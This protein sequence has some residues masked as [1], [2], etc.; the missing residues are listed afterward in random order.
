MARVDGI[1][2]R[3]GGAPGGL[4]GAA[5]PILRVL[6]PDAAAVINEPEAQ[7]HWAAIA[8]ARPDGLNVWR[9]SPQARP[10]DRGWDGHAF[11]RDVF[12]NLD[13]HH[14]RTGRYPDNI[15]LLNELNLDYERG[16]DHH[17]GGAFDTNPKNWPGLYAKIARFMRDLL[18]SCKERAAD[19]RFAPRWWFQ[20][21]SPGHGEQ[22]DEIAALW[23]PVAKQ[24]DGVCFHAYYDA[25]T[26]THDALWYAETFPA[27]PLLLGEWNTD[28]FPGDRIA[29]DARVR[30][31][32]RRLGEA[33]PRLWACYFIWRWEQDQGR[34]NY[35][36]EGNDARLALWDGRAQLPADDWAA[37]PPPPPLPDPPPPPA[38]AGP[39]PF[40]FWS[41][42]QIAEASGCPVEAVA[43]NWP[44]IVAQ[45]DLAG[46][47][48][49]AVQMAVIGTL[50]IETASTFAP[51]REGC[52][53][54][55]EPDGQPDG[56]SPAE[57]FRRTLRY[58]PWYGRGF[59]QATEAAY[60]DGPKIAAFWGAD[61]N[62]PTFDLRAHPDNLL[63]VDMSAA[64]TALFF[65]DKRALPSASYPEG[66][67]L[68]EAC[69]AFDYEW[70]RRLVQGGTN[71]L[72]RLVAV[73]TALGVPTS[74]PEPAPLAYNADAPPERQ[75]QSW[76]CSIRTTAWMLDTLGLGVEI[77]ALQD[78][79]SPAYVTPQLGLLDG[80]GHGL[81]AVL[82]A[83]LP[84]GTP[85]EVLWA[86]T[87]DDLAARAGRGPCGIGSGGLYHWLGVAR[88]LD[89]Q[90]MRTANPAPNYPPASPLGDRLTRAQ[91]DQWSPWALV[92]VPVVAAESAPTAPPAPPPEPDLAAQIER[93]RV[94]I[95]HLAREVADALDAT[96]TDP[97]GAITS[98][99]TKAEILKR[100][101]A[102]SE[103]ARNVG[104]ELRRHIPEAS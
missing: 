44:R 61:P 48:D 15:L 26:V 3:T 18:V 41:A 90:T 12:K 68:L 60:D 31:R 20:A 94:V 72:D 47:N 89:E 16:E 83:H 40:Q 69:R 75:V 102:A 59:D 2:W 25:D 79:M 78:E 10:A 62:D 57:R 71:G 55:E 7:W 64:H 67:T 58:Y 1:H 76:T 98:K 36:I 65:R 84:P 45:L 13:A 56:L 50:A 88:Q 80:H 4:D 49:R 46:I 33:I 96:V 81:A 91:F 93:D 66:Y 38:P 85:V 35:D 21:W 87:W 34:R 29:E 103:Q 99:L 5:D 51:V 11:S 6:A 104:A 24:F 14:D 32:L 17:D 74:N 9:A 77:G 53:Q 27:H 86:P 70:V 43:A 101:A 97:L 100:V 30:S 82:K 92:F 52:Y 39:D 22:Q 42:A 95:D 19:R 37:V 8:D 73:V 28:N 23:V 54:G 63:D